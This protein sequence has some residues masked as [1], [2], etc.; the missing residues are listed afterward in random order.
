[1][2]EIRRSA[3]LLSVMTVVILSALAQDQ[4]HPL[5]V[6]AIGAP[7]LVMR[8][9]DQLTGFS[10]DLWNEIAARM[11]VQTSYQVVSSVVHISMH[12]HQASRSRRR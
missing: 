12:S 9:G 10:I 3:A 7:P 11:K 1:M 6:V 8:D 2:A 4:P 5:R